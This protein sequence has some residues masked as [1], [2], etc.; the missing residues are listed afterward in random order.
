GDDLRKL[1]SDNRKALDLVKAGIAR[2][3]FQVP[4]VISGKVEEHL[5]SESTKVLLACRNLTYMKMA[6]SKML[7]LDGKLESAGEECISLLRFG[8]VISA[9]DTYLIQYLVGV[10]IQS[11]GF[12]L[13]QWLAVRVPEPLME[14]LLKALG[15]RPSK[16]KQFTHALQMEFGSFFL[17]N[18]DDFPD[19]GNPTE[20]AKALAA[21]L[22]GEDR[23]TL[24]KRIEALLE[25]HPRPFDKPQTVR[26][27]GD[28]FLRLMKNA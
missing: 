3:G 2:G 15:S 4:Q 19:Q 9:G 8:E 5:V 16:R 17:R 21:D 23:D 24:A 1:E 11:L 18:L 22:K 26:L 25:G 28:F 7:A 10:S 6:R 14:R 27:A 13:L 20:V 12:K